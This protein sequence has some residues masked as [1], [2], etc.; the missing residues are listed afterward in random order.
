VASSQPVSETVGWFWLLH[1]EERKMAPAVKLHG[2]C[3]ACHHLFSHMPAV[4]LA[5][6]YH[7]FPLYLP[8]C[9]P[10]SLHFPFWNLFT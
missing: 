4:S 9:L 8:A 2:I 1:G 10:P 7:H 5:R 6:Q 3:A